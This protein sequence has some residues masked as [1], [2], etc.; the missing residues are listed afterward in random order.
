MS[1]EK[2][3]AEPKTSLTEDTALV[4]K[5]QSRL[6]SVDLSNDTPATKVE[7]E[8]VEQTPAPETPAEKPAETETPAKEEEKVEEE[9]VTEGGDEKPVE[10]AVAAP[11]VST[12]PAAYRRSAKSRE[13]TDA[14]IDAFVT[15]NPELALKTLGKIHES[16]VKEI[17]EWAE[18]GRKA[19]QAPGAASAPAASPAPVQSPASPAISPLQPVNIQELVE[20][21]G[22]E[23]LI[24]ALA[25]PMNAQA[26]ALQPI[27][28]QALEA[29]KVAEQSKQENLGKL[30]E[31][32]FTANEMKPFTPVYG[33]VKAGLTKEQVDSRTKVL[34]TADALLAGAAAQGRSLSVEDALTAAHDSVASTFKESVIRNQIRTQTKTREK[35][36]TLRPAGKAASSATAPPRD[37]EE[38]ISRVSDRLRGVFG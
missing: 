9:V 3:A 36:I 29:Q 10:E 7:E 19:R 34:E 13:W 12:L 23:E 16:R 11:A 20:K 21:F 8:V 1:E 17:N 5:I 32:F 37:R 33:T 15:A 38:L 22:N 30:I 25:G 14:E 26:A 4:D 27:I 6:D 24:K 28:Q 2:L 18:L 35:G 31:G